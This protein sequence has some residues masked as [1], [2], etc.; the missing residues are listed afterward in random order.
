MGYISLTIVAFLVAFASPVVLATD[1]APIPEDR[2]QIPQWFQTNVAPYF[3]RKGTLDPA[4]EAAETARQI[5]TVISY[6]IVRYS[7]LVLIN[8]INKHN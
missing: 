7:G 5:I 2:S 1:T 6:N 3:Q 8:S 4:L